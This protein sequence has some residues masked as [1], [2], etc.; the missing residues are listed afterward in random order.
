MLKHLAILTALVIGSFATA[1]ADPL[2]ITGNLNT[3][4]STTWFSQGLLEF[5]GNTIILDSS[6][7][8]FAAWAASGSSATYQ[9]L[10]FW[11]FGSNASTS[12]AEIFKGVDS[13]GNAWQIDL[14]SLSGSNGYDAATGTVSVAGYGTFIDSAYA[15]TDVYFSITTQGAEGVQNSYSN[16]VIEQSPVPE[17]ESLAL[18]GTGLLG[19]VGIARRKF[20]A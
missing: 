15:D 9:A 11:G 7:G 13:N 4:G 18:F 12:G 8:D 6:T 14:L 10:N 17:P 3:A 20:K 19:I 2:P 16:L 5:G 1:K